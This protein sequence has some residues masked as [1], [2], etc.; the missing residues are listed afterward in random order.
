M[1]KAYC[2]LYTIFCLGKQ[3]S[4]FYIKTC[5]LKLLKSFNGFK[6]LFWP[7]TFLICKLKGDNNS[8]K[9]FGSHFS[10]IIKGYHTTIVWCNKMPGCTQ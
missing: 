3:E 8:N 2:V 1:K 5:P 7:I 9:D 4:V 10:R 6:V